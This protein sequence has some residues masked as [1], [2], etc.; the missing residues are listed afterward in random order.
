MLMS[1]K[2]AY[3]LFTKEFEDIAVGASKFCSL[4]PFQV[5]LFEK[6][7]HN[8][9]VCQYHIRLLLTALEQHTTLSTTF[10]GF[11]SQVTCEEE[12]RD[13]I[14]RRCDIC[15]HSIEKFK[16]SAEDSIIYINNGK[17]QTDELKRLQYPFYV[18]A[19][20]KNQMNYL[21]LHRYIKRKQ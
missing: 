12:N 16:P 17:N 18:F 11:V 6:I 2:E 19:D 7:P 5:K 15:K 10:S 1:L 14:Y 3:E 21:L 20:L 9:C 4:R 13:C 8:V